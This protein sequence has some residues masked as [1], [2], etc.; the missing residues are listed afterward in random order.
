MNR[1]KSLD[2]EMLLLHDHLT[3]KQHPNCISGTDLLR[4]FD[5]LPHW[6]RIS[7]IAWNKLNSS[8]VKASSPEAFKSALAVAR[9]R[10]PPPT[11]PTQPCRNLRQTTECSYHVKLL[12]RLWRS[13]RSDLLSHPV[14]VL[15]P[16]QPVLALTLS[17]QV[18]GRVA[19][20]EPSC[21]TFQMK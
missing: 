11:L 20:S 6:D 15:A 16:G 21:N 14:S 5:M 10:W 17:H 4:Q 12:W 9:R 3:P 1:Q 18:P 8:I 7:I 2:T 13:C 19:S